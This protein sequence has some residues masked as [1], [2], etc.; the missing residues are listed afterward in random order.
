MNAFL[1]LFIKIINTV[2]LRFQHFLGI[3][4]RENIV[5]S[6]PISAGFGDTLQILVENQGRI[7]Y[8]IA[9]DFKGILGAVKLNNVTLDDWTITGFPLDNYDKLQNMLHQTTSPQDN[10]LTKEK[11]SNKIYLRTGPTI[12][13]GSFEIT[14]DKIYD[15]YFDSTGW[16]KVSSHYIEAFYFK[17][18]Y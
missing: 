10:S 8:G 2:C 6:L 14:S 13:E 15:T 5:N 12:F 7:N 4:S 17:R 3:L 16:G 1:L 9:N 11:H 18:F